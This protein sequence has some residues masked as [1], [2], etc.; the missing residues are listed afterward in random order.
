MAQ[1]KVNDPNALVNGETIYSMIAGMGAFKNTALKVLSENGIEN[2]TPGNWY[3]FQG[4]MSAFET[5]FNRVGPK[6]IYMIGKSIPANAVFPPEINGFESAMHSLGFAYKSN[7]QG[8]NIGDVTFKFTG[9]KS[10]VVMN[11]TAYPEACDE[12]LVTAM[13][14]RFKP[15][16]TI[17]VKIRLDETKMNKSKGGDASHF[18]LEW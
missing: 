9:P 6:S 7:H 10:A 14:N 8:S 18:I 11:S 12:G 2:P 16:G 5:I 4:F 1:F 3:S 13:A 15:E 17:L